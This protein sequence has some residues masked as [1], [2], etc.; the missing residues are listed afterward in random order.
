MAARNQGL[1]AAT[2]QVLAPSLSVSATTTYHTAEVDGL[3]VFYR[4]AGPKD[5]PTLVLLD[6]VP[7]SSACSPR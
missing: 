5:A 1:R 3:Q 6:G 7:F 2:D 4:E